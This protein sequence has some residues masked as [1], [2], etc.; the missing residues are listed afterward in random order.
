MQ[1]QRESK[2]RDGS[3]FHQKSTI[4]DPLLS[5]FLS[6]REETCFTGIHLM[7]DLVVSFEGAN[8]SPGGAIK[9]AAASYIFLV[10]IRKDAK[11]AKS[12]CISL[13]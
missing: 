13:K 4:V 10:S 9:A 7:L 6:K 2:S 11:K 1:Q 5:F 8:N 12:E 3:D